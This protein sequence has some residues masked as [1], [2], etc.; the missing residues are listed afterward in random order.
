[1]RN[2]AEY[3][4]VYEVLYITL[5]IRAPSG[6][7]ETGSGSI[8]EGTGFM[9]LDVDRIDFT[10]NNDVKVYNEQD[11]ETRLNQ[12]YGAKLQMFITGYITSDS[13]LE[14]VNLFTKTQNL[15]LAGRQW[16]HGLGAQD[17]NEFPEVTWNSR[18]YD[19]LFQKIITID[20]AEIGDEIIDYQLG[21]ILV[22]DR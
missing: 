21:M 14:G 15:I 3:R 19:F 11:K 2:Y 13:D 1:M 22:H 8:W 17:I 10:V 5:E 6:L 20:K 12:F 4:Q 16:Y 9:E 18:T 7:R